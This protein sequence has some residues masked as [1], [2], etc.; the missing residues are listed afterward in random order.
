MMPLVTI[1]TTGDP[2]IPY[3][4][5]ALYTLKTL[6]AGSFFQRTNIPVAAYGHCSFTSGEILAAFAIMVLR[7]TGTNLSSSIQSMLPEAHRAAF[8][9]A[10]QTG[11]LIPE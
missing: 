6:A 5:E 9:A 7:D 2:L 10:S 1:H 11:G 8:Q 4:Q 3:S